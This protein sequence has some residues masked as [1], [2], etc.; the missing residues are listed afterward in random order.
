MVD[1]P[2]FKDVLKRRRPYRSTV[3]RK[4]EPDTVLVG[5]RV[6]RKIKD[7]FD[8]AVWIRGDM[9]QTVFKRLMV[10]YI[11]GVRYE[12]ANR[13]SKNNRPG[14]E[15]PSDKEPDKEGKN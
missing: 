10:E 1:N 14:G 4:S 8:E 3:G 9:K 6:S 13:K 5:F 2:S 12:E 15:G 11:E 7:E